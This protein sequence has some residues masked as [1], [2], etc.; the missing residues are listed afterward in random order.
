[1]K[2]ARRR[3]ALQ[4]RCRD[5]V[6]VFVEAGGYVGF[7]GAALVDVEAVAETPLFAGLESEGAVEVGEVG[8]DGA[9]AS[10]EPGVRVVAVRRVVEH[11]D[12]ED[13]GLLADGAGEGAAAVHPLGALR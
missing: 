10:D 7:G 4:D 9:V 6:G 13:L 2:W 3:R 5:R 8:A 12:A 11:G 1:M